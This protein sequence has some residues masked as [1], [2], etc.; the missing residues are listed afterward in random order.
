MRFPL[1]AWLLLP[2]VLAAAPLR[3]Q[4]TA[5]DPAASPPSGNS[6]AP[7]QPAI[8]DL[9][10]VV[11]S[12][13]QPGPG[14]WKVSDAQGHVLWVLGT[15]S[16]LPKRM[17][18]RS[19]DVEA[20]IASSQEVLSAPYAAL[21]SGRGFF[22]TLLLLPSLLKARQNPDGKTL[23]EVLP[24]EQYARWQALK[25]R[26]IGGD[27]GV[28]KWRPIFAAQELYEAAMR[29]S[30][31]SQDPI[32]QKL[33]ADT[34]RRHGVVQV[35][36]VVTVRLDDPRGALKEFRRTALGDGECFAR[37]LDRIDGDMRNIRARANAWAVGDIE[38]LRRIPS[39]DQYGAC[40]AAVTQTGLAHKLG[41]D[42][43][44]QR[45]IDHW[46]ELAQAALA[47]NASTFSTLTMA[48]ALQ[49][50]GPLQ[51]LA[52]RGYTVEAPE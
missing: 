46:M 23:R 26:Y 34:A 4:Q 14:M 43:L 21:D 11:V 25:A 5:A 39:G 2:I 33:V 42:D 36:S 1:P 45:A 13:A 44:N 38:Q 10:Q 52:A 12:G 51:R 47:K 6:A 48:L 18:W 9:Q 32:V 8:V 3:A 30:G 37:T 28:E 22:G 27:R 29:R 7:A 20:A 17:E 16:P 50:D 19:Q 41:I 24:P 49:Q 31:L 40:V 35:K 15:L